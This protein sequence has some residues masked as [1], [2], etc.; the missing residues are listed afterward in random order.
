MFGPEEEAIN[1]LRAAQALELGS[2]KIGAIRP[3]DV[4]EIAAEL[5]TR[6]PDLRLTVTLGS[7]PEILEGLLKFDFDVGVVGREPQDPRFF[8][9]F[10]NKHHIL[11]VANAS[12]PLARRRS[13]KIEELEGQDFIVRAPSSTTRDLRSGLAEGRRHDQADHGDQQSRSRECGGPARY[14]YR[15]DF[16]IR[17]RGARKAQ[18]AEPE[19]RRN[20]QSRPRG[21]PRRTAQASAH[22]KRAARRPRSPC[23]QGC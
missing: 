20:L 7:G 11:I 9:R 10:Y 5:R 13:I 1:L 6:Y 4:M 2:L 22:A 8:G 12:H 17:N 23:R 14:R 19:Q 3:S 21:L 15:G 18:G 16:G